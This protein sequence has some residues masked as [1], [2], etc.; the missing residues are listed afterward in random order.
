MLPSHLDQSVIVYNLF[1]EIML[2]SWLV[3]L[4]IPQRLITDHPELH[5]DIGVFLHRV[6]I[7]VDEI[8]FRIARETVKER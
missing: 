5:S 4:R 1:R 7:K 2:R 8:V 3:H 6:G